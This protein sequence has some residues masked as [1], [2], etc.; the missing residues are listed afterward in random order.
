MNYEFLLSFSPSI[1]TVI[2]RDVAFWEQFDYELAR[3][4]SFRNVLALVTAGSGTFQ[5]DKQTVTLT[6]GLLFQFG[7][8]MR[9]RINTT[10]QQ[11]L[12][13]ISIQ[14]VF[15][16]LGWDGIAYQ[17]KGQTQGGLPMP[18]VFDTHN[19]M[20]L[21]E[22]F[23]E[24]H[25]CWEKHAA[26][27]EWQAKLLLLR[28]TERLA[29]L[30]SGRLGD[31]R[32]TD[33]IVNRTIEYMKRNMAEPLGRDR[34]ARQCSLSPGYFSAFFKLHTG[35]SPMQYLLK[36]RM[37]AARRILRETRMPIAEVAAK[38]GFADSFYFARLFKK[39]N[40]LSPS[41]YRCM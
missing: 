2:K 8:G 15:G 14:Y 16:E 20:E 19:D 33:E 3:E 34:L 6:P 7:P 39:E 24:L 1:V 37:D 26:G 4:R 28:L 27:Y 25:T 32:D 36:I 12:Q 38:V 22:L 5:C 10:P 30:V 17:W 29:G 35:Y 13:F 9:F 21:G 41:D 18:V 31:R 11:P 23:R 40:G